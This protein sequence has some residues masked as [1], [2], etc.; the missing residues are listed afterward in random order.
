MPTATNRSRLAG[1]GVRYPAVTQCSMRRQA[2][3][4][5]RAAEQATHLTTP[6]PSATTGLALPQ[7]PLTHTELSRNGSVKLPDARRGGILLQSLQPG[8]LTQVGIRTSGPYRVCAIAGARD[9]IAITPFVPTDP[10]AIRTSV[11]A[12][13]GAYRYRARGPWSPSRA[14]AVA[15]SG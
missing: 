8:H 6:P 1:G 3:G 14:A 2:G 9:I 15:L 4:E 11:H 10:R 12:S 7:G 13:I 5:A